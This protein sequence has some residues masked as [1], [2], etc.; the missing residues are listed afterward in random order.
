MI[1][2][3]GPAL[4][5]CL[6]QNE[7]YNFEGL[8]RNQSD[9]RHK[10]HSEFQ[11]LARVVSIPWHQI[12]YA[13]YISEKEAAGDSELL[14]WLI[15][16]I[17]FESGS[18]HLRSD[19]TDFKKDLDKW[20]FIEKEFFPGSESEFIENCSKIKG[21][22]E[23]L[24]PSYRTI[25]EQNGQIFGSE[26]SHSPFIYLKERNI[27]YI[28]KYFKMEKEL[29]NCFEHHSMNGEASGGN[30]YSSEI[31]TVIEELNRTGKHLLTEKTAE[32]TAKVL[33]QKLVILS[34]GPGT[35]KTTTVTAILRIIKALERQSVLP[36]TIRIRLAAPTGR[37]ANRMIESIGSEMKT[38]PLKDIDP[39]LPEKAYT[40]HKL[41]GINPLRQNV[42]YSKERPIPA[43]LIILDE[44]SMVDAR[45][46]TLLFEALSPSSTLL[47]V[48]DKDQLPS[49]DAGAV[50]GDIVSNAESVHH[51]L[52]NHTVILNTSWRSSS[53]ILDVARQVIEGN[54]ETALTLLKKETG[55][56]SYKPIPS[57]EK[58]V[59]AIMDKYQV[60]TFAGPGKRFYSR[61]DPESVEVELLER[62]FSVFENF[63]LLIPSRRGNYGVDKINSSIN[64][65]VSGRESALYHGQPIM[66]KTN[67][68][69]LNLFNGDRGLILN[70]GGEFYAVFREG[71]EK[72]R[73]I[74]AGKLNS[75]ETAFAQTIHK[76]QGSEFGEVMVLIPEGSER[77]L[78]REIIY[79][80]I[81]RSR[82][83]LTILSSDQIFLDAVSREVIRH[84]GI[85]EF[86]GGTD[87]Q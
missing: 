58:L 50:F 57:L 44:A 78:T 87:G 86:L 31:A 62:V 24:I 60:L 8:K 36:R 69:N 81:T 51:K 70:F 10:S 67:D 85:R 63:A 64:L 21:I 34:G 48:G 40:L 17:L 38:N 74:P 79:T 30:L 29:L 4:L 80:G 56:I 77:L 37:A 25:I 73:Y 14:R 46:M 82:K 6:K 52:H 39:L 76:S 45:M 5:S 15:L 47:L 23:D 16:H 7:K 59:P 20:F 43:D 3:Y 55:D 18:G 35:G 83:K 41:L 2:S 84:S 28:R 53:A 42:L 13:L 71:P 1:K 61:R 49:V 32:I 26:K 68:Y 19:L 65:A 11:T 72:F 9:S 27:L 33:N 12:Y 66:I 54:G 22:K 75:Y